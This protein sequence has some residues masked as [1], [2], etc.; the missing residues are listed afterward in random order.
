MAVSI[1]GNLNFMNITLSGK[2]NPV[3][4]Q[5]KSSKASS[6]TASVRIVRERENL[7][8]ISSIRISNITII[9]ENATELRNHD[10]I[11]ATRKKKE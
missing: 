5:H 2:P 9:L 7:I 4:P 3:P 11:F 1:L 8:M 6:K 10:S